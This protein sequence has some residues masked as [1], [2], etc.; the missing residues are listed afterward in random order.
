MIPD[1]TCCT[2]EFGNKAGTEEGFLGRLLEGILTSIE[3]E[4]SES[5]VAG[6]LEFCGFL[7]F[8]S[9]SNL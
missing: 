3:V 8:R 7:F 4:I 2:P 1:G 6:I 9:S 5:N